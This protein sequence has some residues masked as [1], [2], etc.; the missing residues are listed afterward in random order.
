MRLLER[1]TMGLLILTIVLS[2]LLQGCALN[3]NKLAY[4]TDYYRLKMN[5]RVESVEYVPDAFPCGDVPRACAC[6]INM[7]PIAGFEP[8]YRIIYATSGLCG[9]VT[10]ERDIARHEV[11]H[12][13]MTKGLALT[14][15]RDVRECMTWYE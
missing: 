4:W 15:E 5:V 10:S 8:T 7:S 11:C 12:V 6:S 13:R 9:I 14:I 3:E 1:V 2:A